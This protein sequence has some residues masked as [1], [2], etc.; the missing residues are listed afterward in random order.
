MSDSIHSVNT[1]GMDDDDEEKPKVSEASN[2]HSDPDHDGGYAW[3]I[4]VSSFFALWVVSF[5][6]LSFG[7]F[8]SVFRDTFG[9]TES[10]LGALG[11]TRLGLST[12]IGN[13]SH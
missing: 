8:V 13:T 12:F 9:W 6:N 10:V 1:V 3:V 11:S 7:I 5:N 2:R 4:V